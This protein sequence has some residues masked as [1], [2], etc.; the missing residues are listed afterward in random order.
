MNT[1]TSDAIWQAQLSA[2][3]MPIVASFLTMASAL[4][5]AYLQKK[6]GVKLN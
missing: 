3:V 4:M 6:M 1:T 2:S 5:I